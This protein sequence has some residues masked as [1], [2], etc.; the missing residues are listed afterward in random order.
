MNRW[1]SRKH[2]GNILA[3]CH[4]CCQSK[5][6]LASRLQLTWEFLKGQHSLLDGDMI[7]GGLLSE[8]QLWQRLPSHEQTGIL[9]QGVPH[10]LGHKWHRS[11]SPGVGLN[12]VDLQ[13]EKTP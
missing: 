2:L 11:R 7:E 4:P 12:D 9:G 6:R 10:C 13:R 1:S 3:G 5:A 8:A